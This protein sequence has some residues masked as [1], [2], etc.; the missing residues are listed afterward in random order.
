[1]SF[2]DFS[3]DFSFITSLES[4]FFFFNKKQKEKKWTSYLHFITYKVLNEVRYFHSTKQVCF[5]LLHSFQ[6]VNELA[7][8]MM[9]SFMTK[10]TYLS[11]ILEISF[12]FVS[13]CFFNNLRYYF[14]YI[15]GLILKTNSVSYNQPHKSILKMFQIIK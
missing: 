5:T 2:I 6:I 8:I 7:L 15:L 14:L 11:F 12:S 9:C 4:N 1:M 3:Q 10:D 13:F